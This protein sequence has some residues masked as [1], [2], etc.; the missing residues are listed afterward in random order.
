MQMH[1]HALAPLRSRSRPFVPQTRYFLHSATYVHDLQRYQIDRLANK[2]CGK[3]FSRVTSLDR[4][5]FQAP[6][7]LLIKRS[8][9]SLRTDS[10]VG[11]QY[12]SPRGS[13]K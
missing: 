7:H 6:R 12:P 2:T 5:D 8:V 1:A 11:N 9:H 4:V 10:D 13:Q 3:F